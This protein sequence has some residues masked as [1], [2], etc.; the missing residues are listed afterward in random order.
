[1]TGPVR[2]L[3]ATPPG[4]FMIN[5]AHRRSDLRSVLPPYSRASA[6]AFL[7]LPLETTRAETSATL[8]V[9]RLPEHEV[10]GE[11][12]GRGARWWLLSAAATDAASR[13]T[14]KLLRR[15]QQI[16]TRTAVRA[17]LNGERRV[18]NSLQQIALVNAR[19]RTYAQALA[20][21][22]QHNLIGVFRG[23]I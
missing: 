11:C 23:E 19:G 7:F 2:G 3:P 18:K 6:T 10:R 5:Q 1:M 4:F 16:H 9:A 13:L 14:R 17:L 21:L 12:E 15:W 20:F 8:R 22:Q